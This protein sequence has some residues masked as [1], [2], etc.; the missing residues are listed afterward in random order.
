MT[1]TRENPL[2]MISL[3][4][5]VQSW[6]LAAMVALKR[7][8][9]VDFAIHAD[10]THEFAG[11]YEHAVKYTPWL[12]ENGVKVVTVEANRPEVV[13]DGGVT[14]VMIPAFTTD[15]DTGSPGQIRRQCTHDWKIMPIRR[16][17][18]TVVKVAPGVVHSL[19]GISLDEFSRMR[20]SD[21][22]YIKN[23]YPL[24]ELRLTRSD[25]MLWLE[26]EGLDIPPKSAC[27]FCPYHS[28]GH[29]KDLKRAG[30]SDWERAVGVDDAIRDKRPKAELFIHPARV[31]LEGAVKIPED[32]GASQLEMELEAPCDGGVCFV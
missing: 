22:A 1:Y 30:G 2:R 20:T 19:Q 24:V 28:L 16:Y 10:T 13:A 5:G 9:P 14:S 11:T 4:W 8:P 12:E 27:T 18:R 7:L 31:P 6:T 26:S 29:W 15:R 3:G 32:Y 17:L 25:C 23:V 21:V